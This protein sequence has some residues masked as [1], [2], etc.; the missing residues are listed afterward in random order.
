MSET[1]NHGYNVPEEGAADWHRPLNENFEQY[2]TDIEIR[3]QEADRDDYEP[4]AGAKFVAT[5]TGVVYLGDGTDW[6]AEM[7]LGTHEENDG[8]SNVVFGTD[9]VQIDGNIE[10]SGTKHFVEAVSTDAGRREVVYTAPEA[11]VARTETS[12]V[13]QLEDGR[14]EISLPDHFRMVTDEDEELLVQTTPYAAD[15]RGLAVVERSVRRLVIEDR[16]GTGDYEFAYTVKGTRE[17][18]AQKE[19][20]RSPIDRE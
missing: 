9:A 5:D 20:V 14:A 17:G 7:V 19:V 4:K 18:H 15:S 3:D 16:D 11:P 6:T 2:D 13:A 10:V 12:G 8:T 1:P